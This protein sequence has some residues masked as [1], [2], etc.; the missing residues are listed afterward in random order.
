MEMK[1]KILDLFIKLLAAVA[2]SV[3]SCI[4]GFVR[5]GLNGQDQS[6]FAE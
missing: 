6:M 3:S 4:E 2:Q 1:V 5:E